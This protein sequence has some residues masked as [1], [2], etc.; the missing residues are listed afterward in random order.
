MLLEQE[1][2]SHL[3]SNGL[4][5]DTLIPD[6]KIH[7]VADTTKG[8]KNT[9]GWY[10]AYR[11]RDSIFV[12]YG[13]HLRDLKGEYTAKDNDKDKSIFE[14][15]PKLAEIKLKQ[16]VAK[17]AKEKKQTRAI[18]KA[19]FTYENELSPITKRKQSE[20]LA[21]KCVDAYNIK[22]GYDYRN[23]FFIAIPYC[24][25]NGA[26]FGFQKIFN[27][28]EKRYYTDAPKQGYFFSIGT[29]NQN[30]PHD[31]YLAEGYATAATVHQAT[32]QPTLCCFDSGNLLPVAQKVRQACPHHKLICAADADKNNVG[33]KKAN[34]AALAVNGYYTLPDFCEIEVGK[35]RPS[36]F[37]D[38]ALL[39]SN[40]KVR[41][42]L[43][44]LQSPVDPNIPENLIKQQPIE[45]LSP[46]QATAKITKIIHQFFND[47]PDRQSYLVKAAAGLGKST[48]TLEAIA[49][50]QLRTVHYF[51]PTHK[52]ADEL[53]AKAEER[54]INVTVRRGREYV[55]KDTGQPICKKSQVIKLLAK[56]GIHR[57]YNLVCEDKKSETY[58]EYYDECKYIQQFKT[59]HTL[60]LMPHEYLTLEYSN[61]EYETHNLPNFVVIDESFHSKLI[62]NGSITLKE[63][64]DSQVDE[65]VKSPIIESLT[66]KKP[67]LTTLR[68]HGVTNQDIEREIAK[69]KGKRGNATGINPGMSLNE[70]IKLLKQLAKE[71]R[72]STARIKRTLKLIAE[73]LESDNRNDCHRVH[74]GAVKAEEKGKVYIHYHYL[75][76]VTRLEE[77]ESVMVRPT[78]LMID[79]DGDKTIAQGTLRDHN[80]NFFDIPVKRN[81]D[82]CQVSNVLIPKGFNTNDK[83]LEAL[84]NITNSLENKKVLIIGPKDIEGKI[85]VRADYLHYGAIRGVDSFKNHDA[86]IVYGYHQPM[87]GDIENQARAIFWDTPYDMSLNQEMFQQPVAYRLTD[88]ST[89]WTD[90][91][92]SPEPMVNLLL[93][94]TREYELQQAIDRIRLVHSPSKKEVIIL[95]KIPLP[96]VEVDRLMPLDNL[97][98]ELSLQAR[99]RGQLQKDNRMK[100]VLSHFFGKGNG[101]PNV[102]P[103]VPSLLQQLMPDEFKG[104]TPAKKWLQNSSSAIESMICSKYHDRNIYI[105]YKDGTFIKSLKLLKFRIVGRNGGRPQRALTTIAI[106]QA[107]EQLMYWLSK[108]VEILTPVADVAGLTVEVG[109]EQ[110][111]L[112]MV[113]ISHKRNLEIQENIE[114]ACRPLP[115]DTTDAL[116]SKVQ[117]FECIDNDCL[118]FLI[119]VGRIEL[120]LELS[121]EGQPDMYRVCH[122]DNNEPDSPTL[123]EFYFSIPFRVLAGQASA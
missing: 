46:D 108:P 10:V 75:K 35:N 83:Y 118:N 45:W 68:E 103:L 70:Q 19:R 4:G 29:I 6:A 34:E 90:V 111:I 74:L 43:Q 95:T 17:A 66:L 65:S 93:K 104:E 67:M 77:I 107:Q 71:N 58:C 115:L 50:L 27:S 76:P 80:I 28:G 47:N 97:V 110:K 36:D 100:R 69:L 109:A 20:Y 2:C 22:Y 11:N 89:Q 31:I 49:R 106:E 21:R 61:L 15:Q 88:G 79:A 98:T 91:H 105:Y 121:R 60:V 119:S 85:D 51:L 72:P 26:I 62:S 52:L 120:D 30:N 23:R 123:V 63:F 8:K 12:K 44:N 73:E 16:K 117:F 81:A 55:A 112:R 33:K 94:Q 32:G 3:Q 102:L 116:I 92:M 84:T 57:V 39:T 86:I 18:A 7:R 99:K 53:V 101:K 14:Q 78:V 5:V 40:D 87:I 82:V 24:D 9:D 13:S 96:D 41:A 56:I 54:G 25:L 122:P 1:V 37:N 113:D 38:L 64:M 48:V 114:V 42:Q 59:E